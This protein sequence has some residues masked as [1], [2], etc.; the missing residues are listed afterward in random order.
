MIV[1]GAPDMLNRLLDRIDRGF[2]YLRNPLLL[3]GRLIVVPDF[4]MEGISK[5]SNYSDTASSMAS[6]DLPA[7]L[8]PA[9]ILLETV[10]SILFGLGLL[11]RLTSLAFAVFALMANFIY[12][13]GATD[14]TAQMLFHANIALVGVFFAYMAFGAGDWSLDALRK[15]RQS[16]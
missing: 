15:R 14:P 9:V 10:G 5:I 8:L 11:T 3:A 1:G 12:N 6:H 13:A 7:F 2:D 16:A 4:L